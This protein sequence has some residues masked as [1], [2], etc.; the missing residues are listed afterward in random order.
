MN[1][2]LDEAQVRA[3]LTWERLIPAL[4]QALIS[5]STGQVTQPVRT[6][7]TVP[8]HNERFAVMPAIHGDVMGAKL[9]TI[10]HGNAEIGIPTHQAIIQLFDAH[11]GSPLASMDGRLITEMRTAA[12][13]AIATR[14]LAHPEARVLAVLGSGV[15]A[16]S[17]IRALSQVR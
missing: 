9:V 15:Q 4:E 2:F 7:L 8:P 14:L 16:R 5:F 13:S 1:R 17:H 6:I 12:V 3:V 10:F 11:N